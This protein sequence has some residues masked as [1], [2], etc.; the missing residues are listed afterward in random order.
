M[1]TIP[2]LI[3]RDHEDNW[4]YFN[5]ILAEDEL[6]AVIKTRPRKKVLY[7][8]GDGKTEFNKLPYYK[9]LKKIKNIAY[10]IGHRIAK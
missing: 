7:K 1:R 4:K 10:M 6:A 9:N 3:K 8:L 2:I 5:P